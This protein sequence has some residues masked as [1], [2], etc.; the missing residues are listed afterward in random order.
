MF[1]ISSIMFIKKY[2]HHF[3]QFLIKLRSDTYTDTYIKPLPTG[4]NGFTTPNTT[5][6]PKSRPPKIFIVRLPS[7]RLTVRIAGCCDLEQ[8]ARTTPL[9]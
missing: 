1:F 4:Y 9:L 6:K 5:P 3:H 8:G 2:W 7:I